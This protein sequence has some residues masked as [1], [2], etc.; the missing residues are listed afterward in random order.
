MN[1]VVLFVSLSTINFQTALNTSDLVCNSNRF[2]IKL[3]YSIIKM[4][5]IYAP[6]PLVFSLETFVVRNYAVMFV[7]LLFLFFL[8]LLICLIVRNICIIKM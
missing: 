1:K 4:C 8:I 3:K 5:L 7:F 2:Q 6:F